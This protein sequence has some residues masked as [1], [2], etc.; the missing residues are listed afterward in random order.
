M[1]SSKDLLIDYPMSSFRG[2]SLFIGMNFIGTELTDKV[3]ESNNSKIVS[4]KT[5]IL[6]Y[7]SRADTP[8]AKRRLKETS[9]KL[10]KLG[11]E[12]EFL[13]HVRFEIF[14]DEIANSEM[15]RGAIE[16]TVLM[17]IGFGLLLV[18]VTLVVY[19]KMRKMS[20]LTIPVIVFTTVLCPFLGCLAAFGLI[21]LLGFPIYTIMCVVPF[22]VQGVGVDD[23]FIMLQ[24]WAQHRHITSLKD[25]MAIVFVHIGPSITITSLTNTISFGI[26]YGKI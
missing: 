24:S 15:V 25:R 9:L 20:R 6:W 17:S 1:N 21:T 13:D 5:I 26:A 7:F 14:G 19:Q 3:F 18:F 12:G 23:S 8:I 10:F 4:A 2:V 22:L 11:Q 16:A